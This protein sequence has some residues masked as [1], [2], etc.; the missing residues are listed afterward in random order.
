M[1]VY[2]LWQS[3]G[4]EISEITLNRQGGIAGKHDLDLSRL[5]HACVDFSNLGQQCTAYLVGTTRSIRDQANVGGAYTQVISD[6]SVKSQMALVDI[7]KMVP[8]LR[9]F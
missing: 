1:E 6:P 5:T 8:V 3:P 2:Q 7:Q 9:S 4:Q